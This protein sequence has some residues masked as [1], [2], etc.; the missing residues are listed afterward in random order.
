[1]LEPE[2]R[3]VSDP[4]PLRDSS[5]VELLGS[6]SFTASSVKEKSATPLTRQESTNQYRQFEKYVHRYGQ[7]SQGNRVPRGCQNRRQSNYSDDCVTAKAV[8]LS[9]LHYASDLK[10]YKQDGK[11]ETNS[12]GQHHV[13]DQTEIG[14]RRE[15][16]LDGLSAKRNQEIESSF[17]RRIGQYRSTDKEQQ[18]T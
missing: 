10:K 1:M 11:F 13:C 2:S 3:P 15:H 9:R 17:E 14:A 18:C 12:K 16:G 4:G 5:G 8:Q 6:S 7:R